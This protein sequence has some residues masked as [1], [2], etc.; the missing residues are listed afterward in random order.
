MQKLNKLHATLD[1][2]GKRETIG[3]SYR[4]LSNFTSK[5]WWLSKSSILKAREYKD[6]MFS[7]CVEIWSSQNVG[8]ILI[9]SRPT[10]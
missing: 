5:M 3:I 9:K 7:K 10:Y 2:K 8:K 4:Y 6:I 1:L